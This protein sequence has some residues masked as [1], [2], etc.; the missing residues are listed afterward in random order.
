MQNP[1]DT[2]HEDPVLRRFRDEVEKLFPGRVEQVILYGSRARG[3]AGPNSDYDLA[4]VLRGYRGG[5]TE[6]ESLADLQWDLL[7]EL[8]ADLSALPLSKHDFEGGSALV[9]EIRRDG[10]A[11]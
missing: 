8:G 4:V 11:L 1:P 9:S 10:V 3:D 7:V 2:L 6:V 5:W